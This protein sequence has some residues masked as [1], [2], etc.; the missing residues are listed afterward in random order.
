MLTVRKAL[1]PGLMCARV[2]CGEEAIE[3]GSVDE[4]EAVVIQTI[5][6]S[7]FEG[8]FANPPFTRTVNPSDSIVLTGIASIQGE[9]V[10][11]LLDTSNQRS[12]VVGKVANTQGWQLIGV[13]GDPANARSWSAQI[14]LPGGEVVT[15]RYQKPPIKKPSAPG[16]GS[17]GSGTPGKAPPMS[18]GQL[19]EAK[20]A[21]V[22]YKAG[23][24]SDG[25]PDKPPP[26]MVAK[27][28]KLSVSQREGINQQ[29]MGYRNQGLGL[30]ER[31]KIY[32]R[33][34][35]REGVR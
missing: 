18:S 20:K 4:D 16:G 9:M 8:L 26:E 33:L 27:L 10:A 14:R 28:S 30:E 22:D 6:A 21:A 29:M 1:L 19:A 31:R 12:Q 13:G 7:V 25:Y 23:F 3:A 17:G 35:E 24:S 5:D 32:E 2:L 34:V 15:V 11:T